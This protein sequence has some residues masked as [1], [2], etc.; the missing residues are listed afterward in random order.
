MTSFIESAHNRETSQEIMDAIL[1]VAGNDEERAS[2]IWG[3]PSEAEL[4]AI[5]ERVTKNGLIDAEEFCWGCDG[6]Q[7]ARNI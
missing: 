2:I 4:L 6:S 5:W 3:A 1:F 7:W